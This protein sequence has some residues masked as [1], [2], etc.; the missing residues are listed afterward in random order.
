MFAYAG[1]V[2]GMTSMDAE[3]I[4]SP[5]GSPRQVVPSPEADHDYPPAGDLS[6]S[7]VA[8][9]FIAVTVAVSIPVITHPLP[10]LSDYINHLA[11][12]HV[13][14]AIANDPDLERFYRIEWQA[15]P[16]LMMDL[17]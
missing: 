2:A 17:R 8:A 14:D 6:G 15:I 3:P 11:T 9:L 16:N 7:S 1:R 4:T 12:A 13:V 5:A 10:P